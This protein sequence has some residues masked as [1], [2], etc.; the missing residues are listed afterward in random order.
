[1]IFKSDGPTTDLSGF[2]DAGS[3]VKGEL[4]FE[5]TFRVDGKLTGRISS[6]GTL[7]IGKGGL[8]VGEI[9][10]AQVFVSGRVEGEIRAS[11]RVQI[12]ATGVVQADIDT[13]TLVIE[14]GALFDGRCVMSARTGATREKAGPKPVSF[15]K[16]R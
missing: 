2:L 8:L 9:E 3:H 10:V 11:Q 16:D 15:T 5:N 7:V 12:A 1:M 6:D 4:N 13:P 14:D